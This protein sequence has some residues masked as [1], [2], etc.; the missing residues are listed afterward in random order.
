MCR[1]F[2]TA[3]WLMMGMCSLA[4]SDNSVDISFHGK[5]IEPPP[6]TINDGQKIE[7]YFGDKV[8]VNK[9]DGINYR[10]PINYRVTCTDGS[11]GDSPGML[12]MTL[13][14]MVTSFDDAALQTTVGDLGIKVYLGA[15]DVMF[16]P[17]TPVVIS[18]NN[19]PSLEAVLVKKTD[20]TLPEGAFEATATLRAE[21]Q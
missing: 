16:V 2:L 18:L 8:G 6:C 3:A 17:N 4:F 14:G 15:G 12:M 1:W 9:V 10:I 20:S 13:S 21:Y 5:L 19:Q 11:D 7:V